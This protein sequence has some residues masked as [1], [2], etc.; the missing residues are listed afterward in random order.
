[1]TK[2]ITLPLTE[3]TIQ[4][5]KAGDSVLEGTVLITMG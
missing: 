4:D 5:L 1:M 2:H 3:D